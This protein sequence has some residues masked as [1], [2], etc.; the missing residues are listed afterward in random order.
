MKY[1]GVLGSIGAQQME[2]ILTAYTLAFFQQYLQEKH[3]PLLD[4]PPASRR[5]P[6]V[7]FRAAP[8]VVR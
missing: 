8:G 5:F 3:S 4:G 2:S 1:F 6:Q 7:V